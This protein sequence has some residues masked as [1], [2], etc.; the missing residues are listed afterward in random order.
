MGESGDQPSVSRPVRPRDAASLIII[1]RSGG[2]LRFLLGRRHESHKFM[3]GKFVFPGGKTDSCDRMVIPARDINPQCLR[4]L[5]AGLGLRGTEARARALALSA[6]REAF[7]EAGILV[8]APSGFTSPHPAWQPFAERR[9]APDLKHVRYIARAITPPQ[10]P[11]RY[12]TR[13]FA[14]FRDLAVETEIA[15]QDSNEMLDF[16]YVTHMQTAGMNLP[17]ITRMILQ[18]MMDRIA[19]DPELNLDHPVPTYR[20]RYAKYVCEFI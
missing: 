15:Q 16:A 2:A 6:V 12:D 13:F 4:R 3:P 7:E 18:S 19:V 9:L 8:G 5:H 20:T 1:D 14:I 10:F 17:G 11:R